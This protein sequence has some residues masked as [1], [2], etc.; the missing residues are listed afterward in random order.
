MHKIVFSYFL[1]DYPLRASTIE[2]SQLTIKIK[3]VYLCLVG[4]ERIMQELAI[5]RAPRCFMR[6]SSGPYNYKVVHFSS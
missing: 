1:R 3:I 6:V 5:A 2:S 4:S